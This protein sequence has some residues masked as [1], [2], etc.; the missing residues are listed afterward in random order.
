MILLFVSKAFKNV[1]RQNK[2]E[3]LLNK[4]GYFQVVWVD[5]VDIA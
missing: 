3:H 5:I 4:L 1:F 2:N